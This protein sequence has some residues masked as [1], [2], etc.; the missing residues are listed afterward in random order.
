MQ[1]HSTII[2]IQDGKITNRQNLVKLL[3]QLK[4]GRYTVEIAALNK[5]SNPQNRYYWGLVVPLIQQGIK[6]LGTDL[7]KE[8]CHEFLK[9]RFN[10][11]EIVNTETGECISIPRSTTALTKEQF[12]EYIAK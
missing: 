3:W 7:T 6:D 2:N 1:K 9:A 11:E 4:D 8:E 5:R 12:S 10:S